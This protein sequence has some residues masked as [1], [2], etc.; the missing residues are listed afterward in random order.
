MFSCLVCADLM[1]RTSYQTYFFI[2]SLESFLFLEKY[3]SKKQDFKMQTLKFSSL[4]KSKQTNQKQ[5]QKNTKIKTKSNEA[6][7]VKKVA[8]SF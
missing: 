2:I 4:K 3:F 7:I 1:L 8:Y 6:F 5:T